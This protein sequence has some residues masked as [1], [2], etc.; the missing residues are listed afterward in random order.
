MLKRCC[1]SYYCGR[2]LQPCDVTQTDDSIEKGGK[3][4]SRVK[5]KHW[6]DFYHYR[7]VVYTH[8]QHTFQFKQ[9]VKVHVAVYDPY[10]H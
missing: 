3:G 1:Q 6:V 9:H 7:V 5:I 4:F 10:K 2:G 8:C